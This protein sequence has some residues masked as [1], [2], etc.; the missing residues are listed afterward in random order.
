MRNKITGESNGDKE[1]KEVV[2]VN[3][4]ESVSE[5]KTDNLDKLDENQDKPENDPGK[6][7]PEKNKELLITLEEI[8]AP[9][10]VLTTKRSKSFKVNAHATPFRKKIVVIRMSDMRYISI[11][12]DQ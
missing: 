11:I 9:G 10:L 3:E 12:H 6:V 8:P 7:V 2:G 5:V 4:E 1:V